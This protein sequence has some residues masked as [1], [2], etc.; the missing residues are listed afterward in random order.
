[1]PGFFIGSGCNY[2]DDPIPGRITSIAPSDCDT[3][4]VMLAEGM[5]SGS[6]ER[7][8]HGMKRHGPRFVGGG[9][10]VGF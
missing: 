4:P 1:M 7:G 2:A 9:D 10:R 8:K 3:L 5:M 6:S